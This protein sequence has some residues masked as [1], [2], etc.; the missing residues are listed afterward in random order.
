[1]IRKQAV[2]TVYGIFGAILNGAKVTELT[3]LVQIK[4]A[5]E[6]SLCL[7]ELLL[8]KF[9]TFAPSVVILWLLVKLTIV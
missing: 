4:A 1:M 5:V 2:G 6:F 7:D 8:V 9:H 3:F